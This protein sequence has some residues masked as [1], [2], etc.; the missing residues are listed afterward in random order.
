M[1]FSKTAVATAVLSL[2]Q[3]SAAAPA[4]EKKAEAKAQSGGEMSIKDS[5]SFTWYNPSVGYGACGWMNSDNDLVAAL[6]NEQFDPQTP[7]G[8]PNRNPLCGRRIRVW[9]N[10]RSVD[11]TLVDRCPQCNWGDLDLSPAAFRALGDQNV[12]RL[13]GDWQ[14]I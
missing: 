1:F 8:N 14:W 5:G 2:L 10:G 11:V 9:S 13:W 7:N 4:A 12:G 6:N 3:L